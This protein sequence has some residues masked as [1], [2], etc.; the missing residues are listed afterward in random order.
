MP[1]LALVP[2]IREAIKQNEIGNASPY[3]LSY[4]CFGAS[5]ASFGVF[6]GDT[7]VNETARET[8]VRALQASGAAPEAIARIM[9]A[10]SQRCP[11]GNPLSQADSITADAALSSDD[12]R[13]L[14]DEMD[15][16]LLRVVLNELDSCIAAAASRNH[17]IE[18]GALLYIA[19]WVNMTGAPDIL[20]KWLAGTQEVGLAPPVGPVV[21]RQDVESYLEA[22]TYFR[23]HPRYFV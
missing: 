20:S 2:A 7:N 18:P 15:A 14:V 23:F 10:V 22:T 16:G 3:R 4:A 11:N 9:A 6:Q 17:T 5:G 1:D 13:T 8:L 19:L 12:G 21:V